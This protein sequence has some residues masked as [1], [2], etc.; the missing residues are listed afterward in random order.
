MVMSSL[1][2]MELSSP[3]ASLLY[4]INPDLQDFLHFPMM[5]VFA[6]LFLDFLRHFDVSPKKR[7]GL[8]IGAGAGF[9]VVLEWIQGVVPGRYPSLTDMLVNLCG[10]GL[11]VGLELLWR[12][13]GSLFFSPPSS[14]S[15]VK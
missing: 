5:L 15:T 4:K 14:G 8:V 3:G 10:L 6:C 7:Y 13:K 9:C 12:K 1:W 2:P 11:G